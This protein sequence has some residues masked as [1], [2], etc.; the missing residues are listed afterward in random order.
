MIITYFGLEFFKLQFG[1]LTLAINPI[2]KSSK[3]KSSHFGADIALVSLD[4]PDFNGVEHLSHG[5]RSPFI[6]S[7]PGEYEIKEIV[8]KGYPIKTTYEGKERWNTVYYLTLDGMNVCFLGILDSPVF[9][10]KLL[11]HIGE[12]DILFVSAS[13]IALSSGDA[14]KATLPFEPSLV[15]PAY[16]DPSSLK[17]FLHEA[18]AEDVKPVDK[19]TVKKKDLEGK[20]GDVLVLKAM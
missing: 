18:G 11:E 4:H 10:E 16:S 8:V 1:N 19:Y 7:G 6:I 5:D 12:V 3:G 17:K 14:H 2:G 15:I 13:G 20:E 9:S